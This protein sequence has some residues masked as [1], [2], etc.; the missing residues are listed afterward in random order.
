MPFVPGKPKTGGRRAG[1]PNRLTTAF[2]EAVQV[3]TNA[4]GGMRPFF[5]GRVKIQLST[6]ALRRG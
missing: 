2:R 6:I 5:S 3:F 4:S 1:V